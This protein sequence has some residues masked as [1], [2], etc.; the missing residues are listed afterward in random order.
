MG[1]RAAITF[2]A[3]GLCS[4]VFASVSVPEPRH[5][6]YAEWPGVKTPAEVVRSHRAS[7]ARIDPKSYAL[8]SNLFPDTSLVSAFDDSAEGEIVFTRIDI[9]GRAV[10]PSGEMQIVQVCRAITGMLSPRGLSDVLVLNENGDLIADWGR[11]CVGGDWELMN[12][13]Y[14][15]Y[16]QQYIDLSDETIAQS[17]I[18]SGRLYDLYYLDDDEEAFIPIAHEWP[19][20]AKRS[21]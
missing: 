11:C 16:Q 4:I 12:G 2:A 19:P 21:E 13:R 5:R 3:M 7:G 9:V 20:L 10:T 8:V 14:L 18:D 6:V 1:R 17:L 15:R